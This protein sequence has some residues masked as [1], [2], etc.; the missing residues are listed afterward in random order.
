MIQDNSLDGSYIRGIVK[1]G[2]RMIILIDIFK[3]ITKEDKE[4][5][6]RAG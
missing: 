6:T 5:I 4:F 1:S 2:N 3:I